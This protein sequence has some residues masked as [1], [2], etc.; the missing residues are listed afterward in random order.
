MAKGSEY[1]QT[2]VIID[3]SN[4]VSDADL[5]IKSQFATI[6]SDPIKYPI[7]ESAD[8]NL[9][10][11]FIHPTND[12]PMNP[13]V[14]G[15]DG[16]RYNMSDTYLGLLTNL[17]DPRTFVVAEPAAA[18]LKNGVSA[19]SYDAFVGANPGEDLGT[20]FNKA[21]NGVYSQ[22]NRYHYYQTYTAEPSIQIG[23]PELC[24]IIAE[25]INRGWITSAEAGGAEDYYKLGIEA[26]MAFYNIPL[27]GTIT[28]YVYVSGSPGASDVKYNT[29]TA[30]VSF[31]NYYNQATVKYA[32][33]NSTG[34]T[35][36]LQQK[37]LALFRHSGLE[38]YYTW[39]RTGVPAFETGPGTGNS[40]RIPLRFQYAG[41]EI[42]AN[43]ENYNA[44]LQSQYGG[45]DDINGMMW[46]LK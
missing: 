22:I 39:R 14:Y 11:I 4:K 8:D 3:M 6:V 18:Q 36:I 38:S 44:A 26:S 2:A 45:N 17:K 32:G 15:F 1:I 16:L 9:Q 42:T 23:Y 21:G 7:M 12:Y 10:Y 24:F 35:Q 37:Y 28:T 5:D 13:D 33:N 43:T 41:S 46:L 31:D 30:T 25:A 27:S 20:M 40:E 34:L 19:T 29:Y